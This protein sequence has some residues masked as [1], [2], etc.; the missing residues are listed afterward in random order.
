[1]VQALQ[2]HSEFRPAVP[3]LNH[4]KEWWA[5]V[6]AVTLKQVTHQCITALQHYSIIDH[7]LLIVYIADRIIYL[8][9]CIDT[10]EQTDLMV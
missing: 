2:K 8:E 4:A 1:M 10:R 9:S 3:V 6:I 5:Y 7:V